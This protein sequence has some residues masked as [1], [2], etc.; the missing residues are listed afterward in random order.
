MGQ[1]LDFL[2]KF[3]LFEKNY[4]CDF[5]L[6]FDAFDKKKLYLKDMQEKF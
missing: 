6:Y 3:F 2:A 1:K 5:S 4:F